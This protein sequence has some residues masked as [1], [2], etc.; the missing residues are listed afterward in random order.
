MWSRL[1]FGLADV[2]NA[3]V[4]KFAGSPE[5]AENVASAICIRAALP[6]DN[7]S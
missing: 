3:V 5:E 7:R 2:A 6:Q 1:R 4:I